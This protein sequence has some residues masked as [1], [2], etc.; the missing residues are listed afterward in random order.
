MARAQIP[1][2]D[3]EKLAEHFNPVKYD[4]DEWVKL[5]KQVGMRYIVITAKHHDGF[6]MFHSSV[7]VQT[8]FR[9]HK[10][11]PDDFPGLSELDFYRLSGNSKQLG[12]L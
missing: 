10:F 12:Y 9:S 3:Y 8:W 4:A 2:K 7:F 11:L 1:V 5:V 6:A